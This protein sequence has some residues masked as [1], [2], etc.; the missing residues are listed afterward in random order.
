MSHPR[1][2][3]G[4]RGEGCTVSDNVTPCYQRTVALPALLRIGEKPLQTAAAHTGK[5][6]RRAVSPVKI[7]EGEAGGVELRTS[8]EKVFAA[9]VRTAHGA[10]GHFESVRGWAVGHGLYASGECTE[11]FLHDF[12][13][14]RCD[15]D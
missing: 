9:A 3:S 7:E 8:L 15:N 13:E 11:E 1:T 12:S 4:N 6:S 10:S 2:D 14:P 5:R